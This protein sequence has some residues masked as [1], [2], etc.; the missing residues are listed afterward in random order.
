MTAPGYRNTNPVQLFIDFTR[1]PL[2]AI[3]DGNFSEYTDPFDLRNTLESFSYNL[4]KG[5]EPGIMKVR[6]VNA[7]QSVEEKLFSWYASVNP[8]SWKARSEEKD[9]SDEAAQASQFFVR[10]GYINSPSDK[11]FQGTTTALSHI[12]KVY[13]FDVG[14]EIG[15]KGERMVTLHL[16]NLYDIS[17]LRSV[18]SQKQGA[19]STYNVDLA[20]PGENL[21]SNSPSK[22]KPAASIVE[23]LL[24]QLAAGEG[25]LSRV[26]LSDE[27][28]NRINEMWERL[29]PSQIPGTTSHETSNLAESFTGD[30]G[31]STSP[32]SIRAGYDAITRFCNG[33]GVSVVLPD[34]GFPASETASSDPPLQVNI[35]QDQEW[36]VNTTVADEDSKYLQAGQSYIEDIRL[37]GNTNLTDYRQ[38]AEGT[39]IG[40]CLLINR[41]RVGG[42]YTTGW[43]VEDIQQALDEDVVYLL[44]LKGVETPG[45]EDVAVVEFNTAPSDIEQLSLVAVSEYVDESDFSY[46]YRPSESPSLAAVLE[47]ALNSLMAQQEQINQSYKDADS[48]VTAQQT[49]QELAENPVPQQQPPQNPPGSGFYASIVT[50]NRHAALQSLVN[51]LN[52]MFFEDLGE[53]IEIN[54][55]ATTVVPKENREEVE[56]AFGAAIDWNSENHICVVGPLSITSKLTAFNSVIKSFP[57][58]VE[59]NPS[60]IS[61]ATGFSKRQDNI[62][63]DLSYRQ[64]K[65]GFFFEFLRSPVIIQQLYNVGK[66]FEDPK[67]RESI[68]QLIELQVARDTL[69]ENA[70]GP[71]QNNHLVPVLAIEKNVETYNIGSEAF[72]EAVANKAFARAAAIVTDNTTVDDVAEGQ[73]TKNKIKDYIAEDLKFIQDNNLMNTFFPFI[74]KESIDTEIAQSFIGPSAEKIV[75]ERKFRYVSSAP[76]TSIFD[77]FDVNSR[78]AAI[79]LASKLRALQSFKKRIV[80]IRLQT[81]GIPELDIQA[82]EISER[83]IA[84]WVSEPRVPGTFHWLTGMYYPIDVRHVIDSKGGYTTEIELLISD[85]N[86][87]EE[88]L[89]SS[90]TFLKQEV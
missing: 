83:K 14:Y 7:S 80:N 22:V 26:Q 52:K 46:I 66:R 20:A 39:V 70:Q 44:P 17:L 51:N 82:Y 48:A 32:N 34:Q 4:T 45:G 54:Q 86:T 10:W 78:D 36:I 75:N 8:R 2:E 28:K 90:L 61:L 15:D 69:G 55:L 79:L 43:R 88:L 19:N 30:Y 77:K 49:A 53:Y 31:N 27:Q 24:G 21:A 6:L 42:F 41:L 71:L 16:Q 74:T 64:T 73:Q 60:T 25:V 35:A 89:K 67:Y 37:K 72:P 47:N 38:S 56:T 81:L 84:L 11:T 5:D 29:G 68:M 40:D 65:A 13:L 62:I 12:H 18:N 3:E 23:E 57:I 50:D 63:T 59:E 76:L 87:E 1:E 85:S 9:W 58:Q 33:L